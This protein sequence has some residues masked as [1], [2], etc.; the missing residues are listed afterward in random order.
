MFFSSVYIKKAMKNS[1]LKVDVQEGPLKFRGKLMVDV[2]VS[3]NVPYFIQMACVL[4]SYYY[5]L[6]RMKEK[7]FDDFLVG[8]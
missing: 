4:G 1:K 2:L 6:Y 3:S 5:E 7:R 8:K